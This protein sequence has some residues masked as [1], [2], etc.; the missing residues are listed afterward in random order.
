MIC[1]W[2]RDARVVIGAKPAD[3]QVEFTDLCSTHNS[4]IEKMMLKDTLG[5]LV[6]DIL[7]KVDRAA[8]AIGLETRVPFLDHDVV[9]FSW[10][11]PVDYKLR[12]GVTKAPLRQI[13]HKYVPRELIERPKMGFGVPIDQW[14]RGPLRDWAEDLLNVERLRN[15]RFFD[16]DQV[17][18]VWAQHLS[19]KRNWQ[20]KLWNIL[21]FQAW[22]DYQ[23]S[24]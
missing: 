19:G 10:K 8:M 2:D 18:S 21:M 1:D 11:L 6:D 17:R 4:L 20:G 15:E 24:N 23:R 7:V 3:D 14:L 9:K 16:I 22:Y 12:K 5:Y 13:L